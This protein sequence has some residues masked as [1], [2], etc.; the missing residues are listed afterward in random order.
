MLDVSNLPT[1]SEILRGL[2]AQVRGKR[3]TGICHNGTTPGVISFDDDKGVWYCHRCAHGGDVVDLIQR[4]LDTDF[5]GACRYLGMEPGKPPEPDPAITRRRRI[6]EGLRSWARRTGREM[7]DEHYARTGL[8][9][10]GLQ[11]LRRDAQDETGWTWLAA[12]YR[13]LAALE[14]A[15]DVIDIGTE[16]Q[17]VDAYR[18]WRAA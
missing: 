8:I 10:L 16:A 12:A 13:G 2:G 3:A 11:R 1:I 7:R 18:Q 17:Q 4:A 5:R 6:R 9:E 15:L 14:H